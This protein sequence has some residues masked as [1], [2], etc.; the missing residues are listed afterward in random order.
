M[1]GLFV[2]KTKK[3]DGFPSFFRILGDL[4]SSASA[5]T[6]GASAAAETTASAAAAK[7]AGRTSTTAKTARSAGR[8]TDGTTG[9]TDSGSG[10]THRRSG[11]CHRPGIG[12]DGSAGPCGCMSLG[13]G[14]GPVSCGCPS[15]LFTDR[16]GG[17]HRDHDNDKRDK[18]NDSNA[19]KA[20]GSIL[21]VINAAI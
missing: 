7:A 6:T 17:N 4:S 10:R 18:Q 19:G 2:M 3:K 14:R 13:W 8:P 16:V 12:A 1:G 21:F 9:S 11:R 5:H 20:N 15:S